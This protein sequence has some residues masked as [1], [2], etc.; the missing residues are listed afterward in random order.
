MT[1]YC[2][3]L[4]Y[5]FNIK[6]DKFLYFLYLINKKLYLNIVFLIYSLY[7]FIT[8]LHI[9]KLKAKKRSICFKYCIRALLFKILCLTVFNCYSII[10][11]SVFVDVA[12][13][14]IYSQLKLSPGLMAL[15]FFATVSS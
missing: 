12:S 15:N 7:F 9:V 3:A 10:F 14:I 13:S 1:Y 6:T 4:I 5:I 11:V 2:K 8:T